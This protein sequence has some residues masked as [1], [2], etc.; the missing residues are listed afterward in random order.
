MIY[1]CVL[2]SHQ[3]GVDRKNNRGSFLQK[4]RTIAA[5]KPLQTLFEFTECKLL[6]FAI[7]IPQSTG[8]VSYAHKS[9]FMGF[10]YRKYSFD[11]IYS[12]QYGGRYIKRIAPAV[13]TISST[14]AT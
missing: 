11:W 9:A 6:V 12:G 3:K 7:Q 5:V 4:E 8:G 10:Y 14:P 1:I 2:F 13:S